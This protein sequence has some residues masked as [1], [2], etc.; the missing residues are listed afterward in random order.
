MGSKSKRKPSVPPPPTLAIGDVVNAQ[1]RKCRQGT[2]H[3]V[4]RKVGVQP[5]FVTCQVCETSH[6]FG[7]LRPV[8]SA[9]EVVERSPA[10]E[11]RTQ[12]AGTDR[13]CRPYDR[14]RRFEIGDF[15]QHP[16]LG[17]GVVVACSSGTVCEV[18]FERGTIR[19]VMGKGAAGK[20]GLIQ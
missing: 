17:D 9:A 5:T 10:E 19:L 11:W 4:V 20:A 16:S 18:A 6:D 13:E 2:E 15:I 14:T 8:I 7:A 12:L 1:C 3:V